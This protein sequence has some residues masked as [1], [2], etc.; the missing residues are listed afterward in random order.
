MYAEDGTDMS[1]VE[2]I[3]QQI[4]SL[5]QAEL[6]ALREWFAQY[7]TELWDKQIQADAESGRLLGLAERALADHEAGRTTEL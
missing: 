5:D 7:D 1:R 3:E 6:K 2:Q 4:T